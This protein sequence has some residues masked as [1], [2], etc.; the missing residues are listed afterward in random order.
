MKL[1]RYGLRARGACVLVAAL[2]SSALLAGGVLA[3]AAAAEPYGSF[4]TDVT[5]A[6]TFYLQLDMGEASTES[7]AGL[8]DWWYNGHAN[9]MWTFNR[10]TETPDDFEIKNQNS[11]QCL[12]TDG[13]PGEQVVQ[14]PCE[15][16][17][18]QQW[19]T[20]L[21]PGTWPDTWGIESAYSHLQLDVYS[22]SPWPGEFIDTWYANG[23]WNQ[24][25]YAG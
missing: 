6:N 9:Q 15:G 14:E 2:G 10:I 23:G 5:P 8:I 18:D 12:T 24:Y 17:I 22:D 7:G 11:G 20:G 13:V 4:T 16:A 1:K 21:R 25:F 19:I 3:S